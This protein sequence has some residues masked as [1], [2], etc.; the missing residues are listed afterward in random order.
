MTTRQK[1]HDAVYGYIRLNYNG[2]DMIDDVINI[3]Y[4]Y[5]LIKIDSKILSLEK[6]MTLLDLVYNQPK[7]Q[8]DLQYLE[9]ID[10]ELLFRASE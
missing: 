9:S 1:Q 2:D 10:T 7:S 4:Q 6:Q 3:I 5:Y 8:E